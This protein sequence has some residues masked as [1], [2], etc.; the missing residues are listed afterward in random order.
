MKYSSSLNVSSPTD[1]NPFGMLTV[2]RS[3][4]VGSEYRYGFNTQEQD[5][6]V[7]G[8]GNLNTAMFWEYDTRLGRRWNVDPINT[9]LESNYAVFTNNPIFMID[10]FG[11]KASTHTDEDGNVIAVYAD[12]DKGV[13]KHKAN[14][15]G[16][17]PTKANIDVRHEKSTSANGENMGETLFIDEFENPQTGEPQGQIIFGESQQW[18]PLIDWGYNHAVN[19][20]LSITMNESKRKGVLDIKENKA[21]APDG[22]MTGRLLNGNYC[23]ARSAGNYLAGLNGVTGT[24]QGQ[25]VGAT[26]YMKLAGAYQ[27]G[28]LN[29]INIIRIITYGESYG[30]APYY[31]EEEYSG[32]QIQI[33]IDAGIKM[34]EK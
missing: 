14:A 34:L 26:T 9:A 25:H 3:W 30:P 23:T 27:Q 31:G 2:G 20:D 5:D 18:Q 7:Y 33:G 12:G 16:G 29:Y 17:T 13:Y 11:N 4:S 6:E 22:P 15:D 8:I 19:Q 1:S 28:K 32:R 21:W 24:F 10:L